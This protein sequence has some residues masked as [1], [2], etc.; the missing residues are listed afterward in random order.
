MDFV[1]EA[2]GEAAGVFEEG[3]GTGGAVFEKGV[4]ADVGVE[5]L[6]RVAAGAL[7]G[8]GDYADFRGG[9]ELGRDGRAELVLDTGV[10]DEVNGAAHGVE[11]EDELR[12]LEVAVVERRLDIHGDGVDEAGA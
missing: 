3:G 1:D 8:A 5:G 9:E 11:V 10:H 7:D 6:E 4:E 2:F 12:D